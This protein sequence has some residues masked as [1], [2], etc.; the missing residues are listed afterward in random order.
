M[1]NRKNKGKLKMDD[2]LTRP[3][4]QGMLITSTLFLISIICLLFAFIPHLVTPFVGKVSEPNSSWLVNHTSQNIQPIQ[5]GIDFI[6]GE[7][8]RR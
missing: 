4:R 7:H 1:K 5:K 8:S 6:E 2:V 3:K